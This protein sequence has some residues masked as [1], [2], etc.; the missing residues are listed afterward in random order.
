[1]LLTPVA[2][3][4]GA[5]IPAEVASSCNNDSRTGWLSLGRRRGRRRLS[6]YDMGGLSRL[7]RSRLD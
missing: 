5:H 1:M 7:A 4:P 6:R 2:R 3:E